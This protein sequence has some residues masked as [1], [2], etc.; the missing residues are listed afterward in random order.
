M[1]A[2]EEDSAFLY[3]LLVVDETVSPFFYLTD[4]APSFWRVNLHQL[5]G[6][7]AASSEGG[8]AEQNPS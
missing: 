5:M 7:I 3:L 6:G 8:W 4:I 2:K 1:A